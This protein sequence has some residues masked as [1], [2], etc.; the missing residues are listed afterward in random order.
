MTKGEHGS[1]DAKLK[2]ETLGKIRVQELNK[3]AEIEGITDVEFL[4]Y[5][6][7]HVTINQEVIK[8]VDKAIQNFNPDVIF[9]PEGLY[10]YYPHNDHIRTGL[11]VYTIVKNMKKELRPRL[12]MYHSY[13]NTNYFPM[14]HWRRQSKS[15]KT[16]IS[17]YYLLIPMYPVRFL[18]GFYFGFRLRRQLRYH[19]LAEAFREVDFQADRHRKL[20]FRQR[21]FRCF[22]LSIKR[23]FNPYGI[24]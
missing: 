14:I 22:I 16:H 7:A 10:P 1:S 15:L 8:R 3:A 11:I 12:F 21:L 23:L 19:F 9:C 20:G 4:G 2:G 18:L 13:V 24:D 5:I 6:D 17:Q